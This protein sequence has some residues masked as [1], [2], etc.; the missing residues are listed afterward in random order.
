MNRREPG[1]SGAAVF[2]ITVIEPRRQ[3]K[4]RLSFD[5][6]HRRRI[7]GSS[8]SL[9]PPLS[10]TLRNDIELWGDAGV[11][12]MHAWLTFEA[13][14]VYLADLMSATGTFLN[15]RRLK[16]GEKST[17]ESGDEIRV[18]KSILIIARVDSAVEVD[19][20]KIIRAR[21]A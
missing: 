5:G 12:E 11:S 4:V 8:T 17:V 1:S 3:G 13:G 15:R 7:I 18:S 21:A 2:E 19:D 16:R 6:R 14:A 9:R 20:P 10:S